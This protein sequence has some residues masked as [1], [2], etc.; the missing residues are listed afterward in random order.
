MEN[1]LAGSVQIVYTF[2]YVK[3]ELFPVLPRYFD[4]HVVEQSPERASLAVFEDDAEVGRLGTGTEEED[5]VR[6]ADNFH[7]STLILK[8][9]QLILLNNL[10][11]NLLNRHDSILPL[12]L[13]NKTIPSFRYFLV[14][15]YICPWNLIILDKSTG[16]IAEK[17]CLAASNLLLDEY[18]F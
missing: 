12:S 13:I 7:N 3:G 6:V 5:Y 14:I 11:L 2:C 9:L 18:L 4:L 10:L 16:L 15:R 17:C 8:L 1:G